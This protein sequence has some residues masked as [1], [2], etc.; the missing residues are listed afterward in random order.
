M[1]DKEA[2]SQKIK[3]SLVATKAKREHQYCRV[4][5]VKVD[6]SKLSKAQLEQLKMTFVQGKWLYNY[7]ISQPDT[8]SL[9]VCKLKQIP[10]FDRNKNQIVSNLTLHSTYKQA[11]QGQ[12]RW[13]T[14]ALKTLRQHGHKTGNFKF[15]SELTSLNIPQFGKDQNGNCSIRGGHLIKVPGIKKLI[16]VNGLEQLNSYSKYEVANALLLNKPDGY[17]ISITIFINKEDI[18]KKETNGKIIGLDFGCKTT[19]TTSEG[20]KFD[21]QVEESEHH[22][23]L[24]QKLHRST[25][26][27]NNRHKTIRKIQREYQKLNNKK[28]DATN[29][30][31]AKLK[32]YDRIVIQDDDFSSWQQNKKLSKKV[33]HSILGRLKAKLKVLDTC[34][35]LDQYIPTSKT[36]RVCGAVNEQLTLGNRTFICLSCGHT[37][38]RDVHAAKNMIQFSNKISVPREPRDFKPVECCNSSIMKQEANML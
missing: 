30:I 33:H 1:T 22:R 21:V 7:L 17:Y 4:I 6:E 20:D 37:E 5:R 25:K 23:R 24:Q 36:C 19:L 28:N 29:Q 16:Y 8:L 34:T 32:H 14:I 15:I 18:P 27:S 26:G 38:D 11:V 35:I 9:N 13:S 3:S 10:R 31:L 12:I 2:K